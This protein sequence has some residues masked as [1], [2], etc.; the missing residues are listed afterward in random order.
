MKEKILK[1]VCN[2]VAEYEMRDEIGTQWGV[3]MVGFADAKH[4]YIQGLPKLV[5]E[6]HGLPQDVMREASIVIAYYVPFTRALAES[7][8]T[9]NLL[10]AP[11]WALAYE[12]TNAMFLKLNDFILSKLVAE[13]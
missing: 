1:W 3:P 11:E 9:D 12:E 4:P 8:K 10:A 5:T 2:F 6:T 13:G 7:N